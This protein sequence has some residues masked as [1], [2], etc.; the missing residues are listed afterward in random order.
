MEPPLDGSL[1]TLLD[2]VDFH[3]EH[4]PDQPWLVYPSL[5]SD[6]GLAAITFKEM[7]LATHRIASELRPGRQGPDEETFAIVLHT[8]NVLYV[9]VMLGV[10][11]AGFVVRT[12]DSGLR[13]CRSC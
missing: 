12:T 5:R 6:G 9:A 2:F 3:A 7:A 11:R 8:D 1:L 13:G 4:N 10:L